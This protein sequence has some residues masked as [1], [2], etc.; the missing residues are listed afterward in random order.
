VGIV[1][2]PPGEYTI[3]LDVDGTKSQAKTAIAP[4]PRLAMNEDDRALQHETVA[5]TMIV[6]QKMALAV[7]AARNLRD[8]IPKLDEGLKKAAPASD[9]L[10]QAAKAFTEKVRALADEIIPKELLSLNSRQLSLRGGSTNQIL[11]SLGNS[12]ASFPGP[13]T[14][15]EIRQ[16]G[17]IEEIVA[18]WVRR[19]NELITTDLPKL[20]EELKAHNVALLTVPQE[21]K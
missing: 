16:V 8:Q 14:A 17:E 18:S 2:A 7:T 20:N 4:D 1:L 10:A 19:L 9:A 11:M 5:K 13:P 3:T 21:I 15:T 12:L 6:T